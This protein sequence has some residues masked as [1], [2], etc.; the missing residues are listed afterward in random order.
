ML[1]KLS[2]SSFLGAIVRMK[3]SAPFPPALFSVDHSFLFVLLK[4][5]HFLFMGKEYVP[6]VLMHDEL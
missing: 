3:R 5:K 6:G 1:M 2:F 4:G